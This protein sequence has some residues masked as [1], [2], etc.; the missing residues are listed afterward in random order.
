MRYSV[1]YYAGITAL[2]LF[3]TTNV[4]AQRRISVP[5]EHPTV[6]VDVDV[7]GP[8]LLAVGDSLSLSFHRYLCAGGDDCDLWVPDSVPT[9]QPRWQSSNLSVATIDRAGRVFGRT[10]GSATILAIAG[11][12]TARVTVRVLPPVKDIRFAKLPR[13]PRVGDTLRVV[14]IARDSGGRT[15]ARIAAVTHIM[16]TGSTGEVGWQDGSGRTRVFIDHPGLLVLVA[17]LAHRTDTLRVRVK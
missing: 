11:R 8:A 17:R 7:G 3:C 1:R 15:V 5:A 6:R 10:N 4:R 13:I 14:A 9:A 12:D 2:V 16:G